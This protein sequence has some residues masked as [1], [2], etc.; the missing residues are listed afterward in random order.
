M[1]III[2]DEYCN[3]GDE[4]N[5]AADE[6]SKERDLRAQN[7]NCNQQEK[8]SECYNAAYYEQGKNGF[9]VEL[10]YSEEGSYTGDLGDKYSEY[11]KFR[12]DNQENDNNE[13]NCN[14][15]ECHNDYERY[16]D[17][18]YEKKCV[19]HCNEAN[20][21]N[22]RDYRKIED[23][24]ECPEECIV[25]NGYNSISK[26][27][28]LKDSSYCLDNLSSPC[29]DNLGSPC[30]DNY[31]NDCDNIN[32]DYYNADNDFNNIN[33]DYENN[34]NSNNCN[35]RKGLIEVTVKLGDRNGV[36]IKGAKINL[37]ELNGVCPKL[38][39]S[40]LTDCNGK[41]IFKNLENGCYRVIS[42]VDRRYFEKPSYI[43]WNE[44]TID[45]CVKEASIG[46]VNKIKPS[47]CRR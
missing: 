13:E 2:N 30:L 5:I 15:E 25:Q 23:L 26:E 33:I 39:E 17:S 29:L 6:Y 16:Y 42:L 40:K 28:D 37:Y 27:Y 21:M 11:E 3:L 4:A 41:V 18:R 32:D 43:T 36:E 31:N 45:D 47:C 8:E 34:Y 20:D 35:C 46:V 19:E 10:Q 9:N 7:I 24:S 14:N 12:C 22:D 1:K 44:V 38:Y